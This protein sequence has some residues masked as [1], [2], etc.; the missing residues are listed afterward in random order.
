MP[1]DAAAGL[2]ARI[3]SAIATIEGEALASRVTPQVIKQALNS[4]HRTY[5]F[6]Y[7]ARVAFL[8]TYL[9]GP[10]F[11]DSHDGH[12]AEHQSSLCFD[13]LYA[14]GDEKRDNPWY[15]NAGLPH[16]I[17]PMIAKFHESMIQMARRTLDDPSVL[18]SFLARV[19]AGNL[20]EIALL[21]DT[22][23][24]ELRENI[25]Y[26]LAAIAAFNHSEAQTAFKVLLD[27]EGAFAQ[28]HSDANWEAMR[29]ADAAITVLAKKYMSTSESIKFAGR[30][31]MAGGTEV[32]R[33]YKQFGE[34]MLIYLI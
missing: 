2:E 18:R 3:K 14:A 30:R 24:R 6:S 10:V 33:V 12:K 28:S 22:G 8:D 20:S 29:A 32:L 4:G 15:D 1:S 5:S 23:R 19:K 11:A 21:P 9:C 25:G 34:D 7:A 17:A 13:A 31:F 27:A 26:G 16:S